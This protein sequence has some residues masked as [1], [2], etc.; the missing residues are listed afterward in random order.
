MPTA[1]RPDR[2][3]LW[4]EF[5]TVTKAATVSLHG[6]TVEVDTAGG[7]QVELIMFAPFDMEIVEVRHQH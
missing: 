3:F 5:R 1:K 6:N 2:A 4:S 7:P